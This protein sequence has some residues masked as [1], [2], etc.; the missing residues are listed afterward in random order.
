MQQY[1]CIYMERGADKE[2][3]VMTNHQIR[4]IADFPD[5]ENLVEEAQLRMARSIGS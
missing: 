2:V 5:Q 1:S 4:K 3:P